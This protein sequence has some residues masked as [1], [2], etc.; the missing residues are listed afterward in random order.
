MNPKHAHIYHVSVSIKGLELRLSGEVDLDEYG[1][2]Q[3]FEDTETGKF[4]NRE[5]TI[6]LIEKHKKLGHEAICTCGYVNS[7][8]FCKGHKKEK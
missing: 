8:G 1:T 3:I 5:E 2:W 7:K 6:A 4:L